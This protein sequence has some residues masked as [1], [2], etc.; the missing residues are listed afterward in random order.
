MKRLLAGV[1]LALF[2]AGAASAQTY[3]RGYTKKDGTY[4]AP[5][6]RSSPNSSTYDNWS[7]KPNVN[8][9][10][11]QQGTKEPQSSYGSSYTSP[12]YG[13]GTSTSRP[14]TSTTPCHYNCSTSSSKPKSPWGY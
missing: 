5:H 1:V 4:V 7:T 10:T 3:V 9:Y 11:G 2:A 12:S 13:Y 6:Y 14:S 8:P